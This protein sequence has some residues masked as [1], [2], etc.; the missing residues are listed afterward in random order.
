MIRLSMLINFIANKKTELLITKRIYFWNMIKSIFK[1]LNLSWMKKW[2]KIKIM[3]KFLRIRIIK[4]LKLNHLNL[5]FKISMI[6]NQ[7]ELNQTMN[8][9]CYKF[10]IKEVMRMKIIG[11]ILKNFRNKT[12]FFR[13]LRRLTLL[14]TFQLIMT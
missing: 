14:N 13:V 5:K 2:T 11:P 12:Q 10:K 8:K 7:L 1:N 6:R 4:I 9:K 3:I